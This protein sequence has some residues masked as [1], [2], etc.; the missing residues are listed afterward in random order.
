MSVG[1]K[2]SRQTEDAVLSQTERPTVDDLPTQTNLEPLIA[3]TCQSPD[4]VCSEGTDP[5]TV[6]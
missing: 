4:T 1:D 6:S 2:S 3:S 5:A